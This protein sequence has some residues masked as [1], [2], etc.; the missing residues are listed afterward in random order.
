METFSK[1]K[2]GKLAK[3]SSDKDKSTIFYGKLRLKS[4][5]CFSALLERHPNFNYRMNI[6]QLVCQKLANQ[7]T[8]VRN[9]ATKTVKKL[10]RVDD[11]NMLEFKVEVLKQL[12]NVLKNRPH[13]HMD[14]TLL[15]CLVL[16]EILVDEGKAKAVDASTKRSQQLHDQLT[17]LR[18]KGKFKEYRE[19]KQ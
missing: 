14:P 7:D 10:L 11:N 2:I 8:E 12:Q 1:L 5:E 18:K 19:V 16:H 13:N 17:K 6:L 15:N 3:G 4:V 9:V